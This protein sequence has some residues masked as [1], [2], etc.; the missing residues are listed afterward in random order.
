MPR[1][2]NNVLSLGRKFS[3]LRSTNFT[4]NAEK[5]SRFRLAIHRELLCHF[6]AYDLIIHVQASTALHL[7]IFYV[8]V[9]MSSRL[10]II[11][12][13]VDPYGCL[14]RYYYCLR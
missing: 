5:Q 1:V 12:R 3:H 11:L 13:F 4:F 8:Y 7:G 14:I 9:V 2:P 6:R 10:I